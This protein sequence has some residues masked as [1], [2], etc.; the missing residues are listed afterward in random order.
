MVRYD[1]RSLVRATVRRCLLGYPAL[2]VG[3]V[4]MICKEDH[5]GIR[6]DNEIKRRPG[7]WDELRGERQL[8]MNRPREMRDA[9]GAAIESWLETVDVRQ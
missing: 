3:G 4:G 8:R 7:Q 1:F 5:R 6:L 2:G 9:L